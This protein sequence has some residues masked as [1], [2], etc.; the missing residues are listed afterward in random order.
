MD[1]LYYTFCAYNILQYN[2]VMVYKSIGSTENPRTKLVYRNDI[3]DKL[4]T[5]IIVKSSYL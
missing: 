4:A 2:I 1:A 5:V 3:L